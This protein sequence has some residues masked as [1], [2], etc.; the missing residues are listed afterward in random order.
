MEISVI[1]IMARVVMAIITMGTGR[2]EGT[3]SRIT[4]LKEQWLE[5]NAIIPTT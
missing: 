4:Q 3:I 5:N 2:T 1:K